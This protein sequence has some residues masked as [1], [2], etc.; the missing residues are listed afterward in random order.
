[1]VRADPAARPSAEEILK[2]FETITA[3]LTEHQKTAR[4]ADR[5]ESAIGG[6]LRDLMYV[7]RGLL[8]HFSPPSTSMSKAD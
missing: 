2:S 4:L 6:F 1:M 7:A 5:S 8:M 3:H